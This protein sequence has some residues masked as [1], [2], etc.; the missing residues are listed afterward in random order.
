MNV[1][2]AVKSTSNAQKQPSPQPAEL[3]FGPLFWNIRDAVIVGDVGSGQIVLC[4]PAAEYLFGYSAAEAQQLRIEELF[5][6]RVRP[7]YR[8]GIAALAAL[9]AEPTRSPGSL[10]ELVALHKSGEEIA[11]EFSVNALDKQDHRYVFAII[12]DCTD[13][14]RHEREQQALLATAQNFAAR[15]SE[16]AVLKADFTAMVA[17]ELGTPISTIRA[18]ADL[19]G[20]QGIPAD[21]RQHILA[22][23]RVEADLLQR[24][25][26]DMHDASRLERGDFEVLPQPIPVSTLLAEAVASMHA[27]LEHHP[28]TLSPAPVAQVL[29]DPER[30]GQVLRN[31]LGNVVKHTPA[32][33]AV[34][35]ESRQAHGRV[36]IE[37]A[38][39]GPGIHPDDIERIFTKF[40]RGRDAEGDRLPGVGLGLYLSR[41]IVRAH[42]GNWV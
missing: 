32:G 6:E 27:T 40:G 31:L 8:E 21:Q 12:R 16:L 24:L 11:I 20:R 14:K 19:L 2:H 28:V 38:D 35:I 39:Q 18:L 15:T 34:E 30:I 25:V 5:P 26:R 7:A 41:R 4:N 37:V 29:A 36:V 22:T 3:G 13:R 17:H 9:P 1:F 33:T 23:I 42:G 10:Y